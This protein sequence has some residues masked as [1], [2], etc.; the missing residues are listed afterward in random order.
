MEIAQTIILGLILLT[1]FVILWHL[2]RESKMPI[3]FKR[4]R[5]EDRYI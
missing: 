1:L 5:K 4:V 2:N 3:D